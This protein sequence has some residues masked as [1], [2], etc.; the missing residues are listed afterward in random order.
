L[1]L[2]ILMVLAIA[3]CSG[4]IS[5]REYSTVLRCPDC[6]TLPVSSIIDGDTFD[7]PRGRVRLF[8]VDTP[9]RGEKCYGPA[10]TALKQLVGRLVRVEL[11]P[12]ALDPGGRF[13]YYVFTEAGNS[14]DE[15]LVQQGLARAWSRDGQYRDHLVGLER[16]AKR[17][18]TG[19]LW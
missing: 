1:P 9:E 18:G 4:S 17:T 2:I 10:T 6:P 3:A 7:T 12:R 11:G 5:I 13:L 19:C 8:G 16:E 14:I 15:M